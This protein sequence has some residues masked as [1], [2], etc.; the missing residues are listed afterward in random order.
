MIEIKPIKSISEVYQIR[1]QRGIEFVTKNLNPGKSVY[2]EK[3]FLDNNIEYR[4]WSHKK[5]KLA[6]GFLSGIRIPILGKGTKVL[7]L[8]ASSGTTVSH[9]SDIVGDNGV[10]YA[11]EF[12][13]RPMRDL[14]HL[15]RQRDNIVPILADARYPEEYSHLVEGVD[16]VYCDVA[17]PNQSE[18]FTNNCL[19]YLKPNGLAY[20]A[21]KTRSIS[22]KGDAKSIFEKEQKKL[23]NSGFKTIKT[24]NISKYH[25]EH[26]VYLGK[27]Q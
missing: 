26:F 7:Y 18:L 23:E 10:I 11:I 22:Q 24:A 21:V 14:L 6:S 20:I 12:S 15:S 1:G 2:G 16:L 17:Q 19:S 5:S 3:L 4:E 13:A 9:V 8:G 25:L 27:L